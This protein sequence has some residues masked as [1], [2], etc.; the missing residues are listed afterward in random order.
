MFYERWFDTGDLIMFSPKEGF[1]CYDES[2]NMSTIKHKT[3]PQ[4]AMFLGY[5]NVDN[6]TTC[7]IF[8]V[9]QEKKIIVSQY[10]IRL[11]SKNTEL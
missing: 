10:D 1:A 4:I 3:E 7:E 8:V 6:F 2:G 9:S 11:I 5:P